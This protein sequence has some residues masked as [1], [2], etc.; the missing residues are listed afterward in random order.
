MTILETLIQLRN[1]IRLWC[2]NNF[3]NKLNKNLGSEENGKSL[4]V[5]AS[6]D[7]VTTS[8][9]ASQS[10]LNN[11]S[12]IVDTKA[13][14]ATTLAGYGITDGATK[15][16]VSEALEGLST[17][18]TV[19]ASVVQAALTAHTSNISNPHGVTYSQ[20]GADKSGAASEA[21]ATAKAYTDTAVSGKANSSHTHIIDDVSEL[22]TTIDTLNSA[23]DNKPGRKMNR[24][25][26]TDADGNARICND[27]EVFNN[28]GDNITID[29]SGVPSANLASGQYST[30]M[31]QR[32]IA[33]MIASTAMGCETTASGD[34]STAMGH[35]T[36]AEGAYSIAMG[37]QTT[38]SG[39]NSAAMNYKTTASGLGATAMGFNTTASNDYSFASGASSKAEG[40]YSIAMGYN[41]EAILDYAVAI[42][43]D[44]TANGGSALAM[45]YGTTAL[46]EF[47]T[48]IGVATTASGSR[49]LATGDTTTASGV[50]STAMGCETT[51]SGDYSTA[52]GWQSTVSGYGSIA[53]GC[54]LS[55]TRDFQIVQGSWNI[56]STQYIHIIGNGEDGVR[57][58]A[59]TLDASGNA[60][61]SGNIKVGGT[62]QDDT[63]AQTLVTKEWVEANFVAKS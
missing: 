3:N 55:S 60:W 29:S 31:G 39:Q 13:D 49:S 35:Q 53:M 38:A 17:D 15:A 14:K 42:G 27:G 54:G 34:Y 19:D 16:Y 32:N 1:D 10:D 9:R 24:V 41:A 50:S 30:A 59:Y 37:K 11:L 33:S 2:I 61:F 63:N 46:G 18:G 51:A 5:N 4:V 22:Q 44:V 56:P 12:S 48:S 8:P 62:S 23:I 20:V 7:I 58:N 47:S 26:Y 40:M 43:S 6:G 21:L 25:V 28:Y 45:G 57:S 52:M 36:K